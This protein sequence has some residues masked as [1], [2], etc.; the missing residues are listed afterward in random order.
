[1]RY[2]DPGVPSLLLETLGF[3]LLNSSAAASG[4]CEEEAPQYPTTGFR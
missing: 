4:V 2:G 3:L 1:M